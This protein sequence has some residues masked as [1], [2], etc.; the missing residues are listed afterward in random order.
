MV[1]LGMGGKTC[2]TKNCGRV[3]EGKTNKQERLHST[4]DGSEKVEEAGRQ[5]VDWSVHR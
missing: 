2:R 3:V 5:T 4:Q 1:P